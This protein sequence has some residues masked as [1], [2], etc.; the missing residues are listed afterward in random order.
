MA[1]M[2][3][4]VVITSDYMDQKASQPWQVMRMVCIWFVLVC[5]KLYGVFSNLQ[6]ITVEQWLNFIALF[7]A[8]EWKSAD[9]GAETGSWTHIAEMVGAWSVLWNANS[10]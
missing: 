3:Y 5:Q 2:F 8:V 10:G 1:R 7:A 9:V 4:R 6:S